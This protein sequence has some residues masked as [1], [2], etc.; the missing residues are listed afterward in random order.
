[1]LSCGRLSHLRIAVPLKELNQG[2]AVAENMKGALAS[3][4]FG[5]TSGCPW[6][7]LLPF[8]LTVV[9]FIAG[10]EE[11]AKMAITRYETRC[12]ATSQVS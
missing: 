11:G 4:S 7:N 2:M 12:D 1:M 9:L 5:G 3:P 10:P 6:A 8:A